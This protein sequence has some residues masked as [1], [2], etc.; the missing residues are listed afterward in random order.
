[1]D[2]LEPDAQKHRNVRNAKYQS[3]EPDRSRQKREIEQKAKELV[4]SWEKSGRKGRQPSYR[5]ALD[6]LSFDKNVRHHEPAEIVALGLKDP[7]PV[8]ERH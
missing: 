3:Y 4:R 6:A 2:A 1:M 8:S 7:R 5:T